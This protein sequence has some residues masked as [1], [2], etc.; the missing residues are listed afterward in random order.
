MRGIGWFLGLG[1]LPRFSIKEKLLQG[2]HSLVSVTNSDTPYPC[3]SFSGE[4]KNM[5]Y[6][7]LLGSNLFRIVNKIFTEGI[8]WIQMKIKFTH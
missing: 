7:I 6:N 3:N 5:S 1:S 8:L 2:Y 4:K